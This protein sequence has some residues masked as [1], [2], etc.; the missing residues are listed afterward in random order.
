VKSRDIS[1]FILT[2]IRTGLSND[3]T[4]GGEVYP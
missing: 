4:E 1:I 2:K 3:G